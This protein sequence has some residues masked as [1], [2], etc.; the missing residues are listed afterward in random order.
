MPGGS[1]VQDERGDQASRATWKQD[2][3][4]P[5]EPGLCACAGRDLL[6]GLGFLPNVLFPR[7]A[8][9]LC[10]NSEL[11]MF[12]F[13]AAGT[14]VSQILRTPGAQPSSSHNR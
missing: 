4:A 3:G 7:V 9:G 5:R 8:Q 6:S 1:A 2:S 14:E 12:A 13:G 10:A 11:A